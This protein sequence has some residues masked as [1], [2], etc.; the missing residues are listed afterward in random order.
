MK[1]TLKH[2]DPD[3]LSHFEQVMHW[4][5]FETVLD[6]I[7]AEYLRTGGKAFVH[8]DVLCDL[9]NGTA[10]DPDTQ[11]TCNHSDGSF[12]RIFV[13]NSDWIVPS[14][15]AEGF[16]LLAHEE[17]RHQAQ[18]G[19]P[20]IPEDVRDM[21]NRT[22]IVPLSNRTLVTIDSIADSMTNLMCEE[23]VEHVFSLIAQMQGLI[24]SG[25]LTIPK[26]TIE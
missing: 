4:L 13:F 14:K 18:E 7:K 3:V 16:V 8:L 25:N 11:K 5:D 6:E 22:G 15:D 24:K 21:I 26:V 1:I 19:D 10:T 17:L 2:P 12:Q 20:S 23:F 9:C